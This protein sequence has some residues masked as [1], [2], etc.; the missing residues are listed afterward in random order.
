MRGRPRL[1]FV[2]LGL[3]SAVALAAC[4]G[5]AATPLPTLPPVTDAPGASESPAVETLAP[6]TEPPASASASAEPS[7][8]AKPAATTIYKVK[9]GDTM[10]GIAAKYGITLKALMKLNPRIK[11]ASK[12]HIGQ[13]IIVPKK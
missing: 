2:A 6:E 4:G 9:K 8:S 12:I 7:A 13:S 1:A 3:S 5:S 11:D 10:T